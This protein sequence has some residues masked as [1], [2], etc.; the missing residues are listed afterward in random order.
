MLVTTLTE[1][2]E[3]VEALATGFAG[4]AGG[5]FLRTLEDLGEVGLHADSTDPMGAAF[6][7]TCTGFGDGGFRGC[8]FPELVALEDLSFSL[9]FL[10]AKVRA[11]HHVRVSSIPEACS[12]PCASVQPRCITLRG[13]FPGSRRRSTCR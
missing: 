4:R 11:P 2:A 3:R 9:G 5:R 10:Q 12:G 7:G 1:F 8:A 13:R 6:S